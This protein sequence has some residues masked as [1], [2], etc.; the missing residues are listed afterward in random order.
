MF[1][2]KTEPNNQ[3][4]VWG[5]TKTRECSICKRTFVGLG[6][7]ADPVNAGR[8]CDECNFEVVCSARLNLMDR[9]QKES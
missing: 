8:C 7:N 5:D 2:D 4:H 9:R 3:T 1:R 6:N